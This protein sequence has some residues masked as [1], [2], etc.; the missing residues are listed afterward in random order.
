MIHCR[1]EMVEEMVAKCCIDKRFCQGS[2]PALGLVHV[3]GGVEHVEAPVPVRPQLV[4]GVVELGP[5]VG[6]GLL[7]DEHVAGHRVDCQPQ[8]E[9]QQGLVGQPAQEEELQ[10]GQEMF[11]QERV[12][13]EDDQVVAEEESCRVGEHGEDVGEDV[14]APRPD[15]TL[16]QRQ[17]EEE[18]LHA[19]DLQVGVGVGVEVVGQ[20]VADLTDKTER[21][22]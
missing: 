18:R 4:P 21:F 11:R 14:L 3:P 16:R 8:L 19:G 12:V 13:S 17:E 6:G 5:V 7:D 2:K 9:G 1:E 10:P 20:A 22:T 15:K